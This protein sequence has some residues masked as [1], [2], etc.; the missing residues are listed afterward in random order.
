VENRP[1]LSVHANAHV[2]RLL[3]SV[4]RRLPPSR[5]KNRLG[6]LAAYALGDPPAARA[7]LGDLRLW[8]RPADRTASEAF[9]SG[10]Y[11]DVFTD[12]LAALLQPGM[13]VLD[14]GA[15]VGLIGLRLASRLRS[16]GGGRV[17]LVEPIPANAHL[18][19]A[20]IRENGLEPLCEVFEVGLSD[21]SGSATLLAEG[22]ANRSGNAGL[23]APRRFRRGLTPIE[24]PLRTLD[25]LAS[26]D[27]PP[28]I[29]LVK[30]D[31]EGAEL[32]ALR[33]G[34]ASVTRSRPL[35]FGEFNPALMERHGGAL[36]QVMDLL[37]PLGYES[38]V[39][40]GT[41]EL[42]RMRPVRGLADVLS[43]VPERLAPL[44]SPGA[45]GWSLRASPG[46]PLPN[47]ARR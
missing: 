10:H 8:L 20:S 7:V 15:N 43:A 44:L 26:D 16:L 6:R 13:T 17:L 42:T 32:A 37:G 25:Q 28:G 40:T 23:L 1:A 47:P 3:G 45:S 18:I 39:V 24:I 2:L 36:P 29:D 30:I 27:G 14:A 31:V 46:D 4:S 22:G 38:F 12:L 5:N 33:G 35:I 34:I 41:R 19:R 11:E 21:K 9:W